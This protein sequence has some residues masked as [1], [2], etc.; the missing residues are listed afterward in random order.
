[1]PSLAAH[2]ATETSL[3]L[4]A[5]LECF[6]YLDSDYDNDLCWGVCGPRLVVYRAS[7]SELISILDLRKEAVSLD[8]AHVVVAAAPSW[9]SPLLVLAVK[10]GVRTVLALYDPFQHSLFAAHVLP[11]RVENIVFLPGFASQLSTT[12]D[13]SCCVACATGNQVFLVA[14]NPAEIARQN[15]EWNVTDDVPDAVRA[16]GWQ[17]LV[18]GS[19]FSLHSIVV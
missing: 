14:L 10:Y 1:M 8:I 3:Y 18:P 2:V 7:S 11:Y 13:S 6:Q 15:E 16:N 9:R 5:G 12:V 4:P 17:T 19:F